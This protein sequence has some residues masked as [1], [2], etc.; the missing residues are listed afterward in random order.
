M[1]LGALTSGS[2][3]HLDGDDID[4]LI[5]HINAKYD[6]DLDLNLDGVANQ[7]DVELLLEGMTISNI[8]PHWITTTA[9]VGFRGV[10]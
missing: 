5:A 6:P 2:D 7:A 9:W 10:Q 4:Y 8:A 3:G 1:L